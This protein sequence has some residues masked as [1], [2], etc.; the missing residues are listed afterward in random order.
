MHNQTWF[1]SMMLLACVL[2]YHFAFHWNWNYLRSHGNYFV[3]FLA[4]VW[5][6]W[7]GS[8][9][10]I[11]HCDIGATAGVVISSARTGLNH[12]LNRVRFHEDA[13]RSSWR[14]VSRQALAEQLSQFSFWGCQEWIKVVIALGLP[15]LFRPDR[16][17]EKIVVQLLLGLL[18]QVANFDCFCGGNLVN[19]NPCVW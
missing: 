6:A 5:K 12:F 13:P 7:V 17:G 8:V 10:W 16:L 19:W 18:R 15:A 11:E 2:K 14:T 1:E 4:L 3:I 9:C